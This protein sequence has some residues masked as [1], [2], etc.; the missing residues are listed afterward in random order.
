MA[1]LQQTR[2]TIVPITGILF[3]LL[4]GCAATDDE[5]D[6][7]SIRANISG[8]T[9]SGLVLQ[10]N[11]TGSIPVASGA[12][13]VL[14]T[15]VAAPDS[16]YAVT[17]LAQPAGL[18]CSVA[19]GSGT[20]TADV[21]N[22]NITCSVAYTISGTISGYT[23]SGLA[24]RLNGQS[25]AAF[26]TTP[27]SGATTF[28]FTASLGTGATY[29]VGVLSQPTNPIQTC[30]PTGGTGTGTVASANVT[31]VTIT[32]QDNMPYTVGGTITGL[33]GAG[34]SLRM[35]YTGTVAPAEISVAVGAPTFAF[36]GATVPANGIFNIG[37]LTQPANQS[38][39]LKGGIGISPSDVT[40]VAVLCV[41]NAPTALVGPY[42]LLT[43]AGRQYFNFNADG[44]FTTALAL[45]DSGCNTVSDTGNGN[46][47][48]YGTFAWNPG[49]S[50][51]TL[52][53]AVAVDTSAECG[54]SNGNVATANM[55]VQKG[56]GTI[57]YQEGGGSSFSLSAIPAPLN[58]SASVVGAYVPE[59][60]N[61]RLLVLHDNNTFLMVETQGRGAA[62]FNT[63]ERGCYAVNGAN[64]TFTIGTGCV[65]DGFSSY[66]FN[67][68][69][70]FGPF[71]ATP[72]IG[73][74][75][76]TIE[77][78]TVLVINGLRWKRSIAN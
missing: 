15:D 69:Y 44:T 76:F 74:L 6:D 50:A 34:L 53:A 32:C 57:T 28:G 51:L 27:A 40:N 61:G 12:T 3:L 7:W 43:A 71:P 63:Q 58:P 68:P 14:I 45:Y 72:T 22:I 11:G 4:G 9:S 67:G 8:L 25:G 41:N 39:V 1:S 5:E 36:A 75:P 26:N 21:N 23:G 29:S 56:V 47:V 30:G 24:L 60:G 37:I 64:I 2:R 19:N 20:A 38:C 66:D 17:V 55:T 33:T 46:G 18:F 49:T 13:T 62:R 70:G 59:A 48:E 65:P 35:N 10:N 77:S 52:P 73:P 78:G 42:T 16:P 54:F 31:N